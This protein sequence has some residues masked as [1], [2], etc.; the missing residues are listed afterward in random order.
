M[1]YAAV[2]IA[3]LGFTIGATFRL[4]FLLGIV[5]LLLPICLIFSVSRGYGLLDTILMV[6][7][8]Q[9]ILQ[10]SY[11]LGLLGRGAI[12]LAQ[13]KLIGL[14]RAHTEQMRRRQDS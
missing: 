8:P 5:L 7:V 12:S 9:A 13:R 6:M 2:A 1:E 10:G 3:I 11:F 14:S 4:R